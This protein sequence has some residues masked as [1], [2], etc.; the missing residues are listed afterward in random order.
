MLDFHRLDSMRV[1][2]R[3]LTRIV[4]PHSFTEFKKEYAGETLRKAPTEASPVTFDDGGVHE[5]LFQE[6]E[7]GE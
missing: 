4:A 1:D 3:S 5:F 2:N 7:T 6:T